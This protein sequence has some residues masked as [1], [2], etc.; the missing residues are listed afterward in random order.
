MSRWGRREAANGQR[1]L[2]RHGCDG[3]GR[4]GMIVLVCSGRVCFRGRTCRWGRWHEAVGS[5]MHRCG[6]GRPGG[7]RSK[8]SA[9]PGVGPWR[10]R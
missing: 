4:I 10:G 9:V 7:A 5:R 1:C 3:A 6:L 2:L 8:V